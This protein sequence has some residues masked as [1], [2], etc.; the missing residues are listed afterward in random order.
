VGNDPF[1]PE[2]LR[3][4]PEDY[5]AKPQPFM[6]GHFLRIGDQDYRV[7]P[8]SDMTP[9]EAYWLVVFVKRFAQQPP[10]GF[11]PE[12]VLAWLAERNPLRHLEAF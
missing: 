12:S 7:L 11:D 2:N 3:L 10:G 6:A 5:A 4:R 9:V 1:D 8:A